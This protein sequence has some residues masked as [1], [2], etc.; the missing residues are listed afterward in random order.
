MFQQ[1][2]KISLHLALVLH[3]LNWTARNVRQWDGERQSLPIIPAFTILHYDSFIGSHILST[4]RHSF[5]IMNMISQDFIS[6]I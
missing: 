2:F 1:S 6:G 3:P 4:H 5:K